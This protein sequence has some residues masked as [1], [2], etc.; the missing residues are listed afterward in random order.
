MRGGNTG[1]EP[2]G[3]RNIRTIASGDDENMS[4]SETITVQFKTGRK[5]TLMQVVF[6]T[7]GMY[8]ICEFARVAE[9][10]CIQIH[11]CS[12]TFGSDYSLKSYWV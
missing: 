1:V 6:E 10:D 9:N 5:S 11:L 8:N 7:T 2:R 4:I 12:S 3:R